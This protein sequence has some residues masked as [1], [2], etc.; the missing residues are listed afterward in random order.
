LGNAFCAVA[1]ALKT[2]VELLQRTSHRDTQE[3]VAAHDSIAIGNTGSA[4]AGYLANWIFESEIR[5]TQVAEE[6]IQAMTTA[7]TSPQRETKLRATDT[8]ASGSGIDLGLWERILQTARSQH[9][10][11]NRLWF[12]QLTPRSFAN[13]VI[14]V[15][16]PDAG[17]A[18]FLPEPMPAAVHASRPAGDRA[19]CRG[20]VLL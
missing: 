3:H 10:S 13:G 7:M 19:A 9:P 17:A 1:T 4:D 6:S 8:S 12:D 20:D 16:T 11:L 15:A 2:C 18:Q 14:Q 5:L